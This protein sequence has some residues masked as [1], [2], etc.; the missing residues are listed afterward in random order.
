MQIYLS[1]GMNEHLAKP[2]E[3]KKVLEVVKKIL[4]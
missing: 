4:H 2:I 3:I 1:A